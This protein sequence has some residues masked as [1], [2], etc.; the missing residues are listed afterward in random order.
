MQANYGHVSCRAVRLR[1]ARLR[2]KVFVA[3]FLQL[4][5]TPLVVI[6]AMIVPAK[7]SITVRIATVVT[8]TLNATKKKEW[9][10]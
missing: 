8:W 1:G 5:L 10:G 4:V 9:S 3:A 2:I 7:G 6:E